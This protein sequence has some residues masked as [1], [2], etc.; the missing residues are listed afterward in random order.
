MLSLLNSN[1]IEVQVLN[2][3]LSILNINV[4]GETLKKEQEEL[5]QLKPKRYE[6]LRLKNKE[7]WE[8]KSMDTAHQSM[9][10]ED[11]IMSED[12]LYILEALSASG[13]RSIRYYKEIQGVKRIITNDIADAAV[14]SIKRNIE[15]NKIDPQR[16]VANQAY[17][18]PI[19]VH[20]VE[21]RPY[22]CMRTAQRRTNSMS[23]IWIPMAL[24]LSLLIVLFKP[25]KTVV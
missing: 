22:I 15:F 25:S 12:G 1:S 2:R 13:L 7:Y 3:D 16:M 11:P 14:Q 24:V 23:L 20:D 19:L 21:M 5:K 8:K 10:I 17:R 6:N 9:S 18:S 4:Y